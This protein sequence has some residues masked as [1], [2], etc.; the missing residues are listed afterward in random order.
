MLI[1]LVDGNIPERDIQL[2][3]VDGRLAVT[4]EDDEDGIEG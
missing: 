4:A 1:G 2:L 3:G